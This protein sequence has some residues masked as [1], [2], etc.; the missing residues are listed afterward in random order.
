MLTHLSQ[1]LLLILS[2]ILPYLVDKWSL[3]V[4]FFIVFF[5]LFVFCRTIFL[6][7]LIIISVLLYLN[8]SPFEGRKIKKSKRNRSR[9]LLE[10]KN[11]ETIIWLDEFIAKK[12]IKTQ[13]ENK[14]KLVF[15]QSFDKIMQHPEYA[16]YIQNVKVINV[17]FPSISNSKVITSNDET[18]NDFSSESRKPVINNIL[19]RFTNS[20]SVTISSFI[21]SLSHNVVSTIN[22]INLDPNINIIS[23]Y[24][25]GS[26]KVLLS[27][28][29]D[30]RIHIVSEEDI[31]LSEDV[32]KSVFTQILRGVD[33]HFDEEDKKEEVKLIRPYEEE[34]EEIEIQERDI[35]LNLNTNEESSNVKA[36]LSLQP[37]VSIHV[38]QHGRSL[39]TKCSFQ[40][41][42][43]N[44]ISIDPVLKENSVV[45]ASQ[46]LTNMFVQTEI[47][48]NEETGEAKKEEE[49]EE[50]SQDD[51]LFLKA[52]LTPMQRS[53]NLIEES[54][55]K[56]Q[57]EEE[58]SSSD[59]HV[60]VSTLKST[61]RSLNIE[62]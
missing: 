4:T 30:P 58:D 32:I 52:R 46:R 55:S 54:S 44:T 31:K 25:L 3:P 16:K 50:E 49:S 41:L 21:P 13:I 53:I 40:Q 26:I 37:S 36:N 33:L 27:F 29:K 34:E 12:V 23:P 39:L 18:T 62:E 45:Q 14:L 8:Y 60:I 51:T 57:Q 6:F 35:A 22:A 9:H 15:Q 59:E 56:D 28:N 17:H 42:A 10:H 43:D 19:L 2:F 38:N 11:S 20:I 48:S 47:H 1:A 24:K 5:S 61:R 7:F